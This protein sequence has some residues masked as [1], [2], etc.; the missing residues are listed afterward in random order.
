M[1]YQIIEETKELWNMWSWMPWSWEWFVMVKW[2]SHPISWCLTVGW[3]TTVCP[4][5]LME[6][7]RIEELQRGDSLSLLDWTGWEGVALNGKQTWKQSPLPIFSWPVVSLRQWL[8]PCLTDC[9]SCNRNYLRWSNEF[10]L[11]PYPS[12][13]FSYHVLKSTIFVPT[14]NKLS[15]I[16]FLVLAGKS[17]SPLYLCAENCAVTWLGILHAIAWLRVDMQD[18]VNAFL[19]N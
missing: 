1:L 14:L 7:W 17:S 15:W 2:P 3:P 6:P 8:H 9:T 4:T 12:I 5:R 10:C 18:V 16:V 19:L 11:H 13:V